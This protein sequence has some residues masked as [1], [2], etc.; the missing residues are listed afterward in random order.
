MTFYL[1]DSELAVLGS[2]ANMNAAQMLCDSVEDVGRP[3]KHAWCRGA[4]LNKILPNRLT[5]GDKRTARSDN[6]TENVETL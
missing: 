3:A 4:H 1:D 6:H 5:S 2:L